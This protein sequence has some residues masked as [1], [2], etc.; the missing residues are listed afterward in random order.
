MLGNIFFTVLA[1]HETTGST[2]GFILLLLAIY[3]ECQK[4]VQNELDEHLRNRPRSQWTLEQDYPALQDGYVGAVQMETLTRYNPSSFLFKKT[5][6]PV[7][8]TDNS[9]GTHSI[10]KDTL[11]M[12]NVAASLRKPAQAEEPQVKSERLDS[13]SSSPALYFNPERWLQGEQKRGNGSSADKQAMTWHVFG[14]GGRTCP[15]RAFAQIELTSVMATLFT[16]YSVELVIADEV[17]RK[18]KGDA[19]LAWSETRDMAIKKLYDDIE[20]NISIGLMK[21]LPIR[22]VKR[23]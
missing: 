13:L 18:N 11:T 19:H 14:A 5:V 20:V 4:R 1:A 23:S 22:L 21:E 3:P 15:G 9:G 12:M 16:E 6:E 7:I 17:L 2:L 8:V 10:P